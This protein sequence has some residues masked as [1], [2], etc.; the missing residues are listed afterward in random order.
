MILGTRRDLEAAGDFGDVQAAAIGVVRLARASSAALTS[1]FGSSFSSRYSI[2]GVIGSG[3]ANT[4]A[5]ITA[6]SCASSIRGV[7]LFGC[8]SG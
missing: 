5:S 6:F 3:D 2:R 8:T 7:L 4:S 1:S